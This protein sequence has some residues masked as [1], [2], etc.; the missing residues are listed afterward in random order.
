MS[1][2]IRVKYF[3]HTEETNAKLTMDENVHIPFNEFELGILWLNTENIAAMH[4][5]YSDSKVTVLEITGASTYFI[6]MEVD[7][8]KETIDSWVKNKQI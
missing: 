3:Q 6:P 7:K 2:L 8:F 4:T 5:H 1:N